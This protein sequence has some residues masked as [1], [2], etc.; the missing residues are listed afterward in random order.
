VPAG[1]SRG[2]ERGRWD[3]R[4]PWWASQG[5]GVILMFASDRSGAWLFERQRFIRFGLHLHSYLEAQP[6]AGSYTLITT[7]LMACTVTMLQ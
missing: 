5:W 2:P 3:R 4:A 6:A 1:V 7:P